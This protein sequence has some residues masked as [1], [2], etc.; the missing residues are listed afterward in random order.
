MEFITNVLALAVV[1]GGFGIW[2]FI[3]K[4]PN[5]KNRNFSIMFTI[6][7]FMLFGI[8]NPNKE[9]EEAQNN[10]STTTNTT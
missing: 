1:L 9:S 4:Q 7:C 10:T 6:V 8:L 3:K 2:W 5:A